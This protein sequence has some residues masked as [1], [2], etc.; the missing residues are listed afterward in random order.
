MA[1]LF[2]HLFSDRHG[3]LAKISIKKLVMTID[4]HKLVALN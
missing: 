1:F 2:L 4:K 3:K